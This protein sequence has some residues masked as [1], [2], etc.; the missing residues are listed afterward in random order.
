MGRED[1]DELGIRQRELALPENIEWM[2]ADDALAC[3]CGTRG[4]AC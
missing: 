2:I 1:V 3:F 4:V